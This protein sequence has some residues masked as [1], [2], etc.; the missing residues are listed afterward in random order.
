MRDSKLLAAFMVAVA[1]AVVAFA[2]YTFGWRDGDGSGEA[3]TES[4]QRQPS[5]TT[6]TG[7]HPLYTI[8]AWDVVLDPET[9]TLCEVTGEAGIPNLF[10]TPSGPRNRYQVVFWN[11]RVDVYDLAAPG[12]PMVPTFSVPARLKPG[13]RYAPR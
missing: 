4:V 10:C 2:V 8:H 13:Q 6:E 12:E 11:D 3:R 7:R 1:G 5:I 9:K